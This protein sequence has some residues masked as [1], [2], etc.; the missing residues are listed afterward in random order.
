MATVAEKKQ[1]NLPHF[2][3]PHDDDQRI[4]MGCPEEGENLRW[5][6]REVTGGDTPAAWDDDD[7]LCGYNF[8]WALAD[9]MA[10]AVCEA[11]GAADCRSVHGERYFMELQHRRTKES[12]KPCFT[13][14]KC[15]N[16]L[17]RKAQI[18]RG[19]GEYRG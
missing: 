3:D 17:T 8:E 5:R 9:M 12:G 15:G 2:P 14:T 13:M 7:F 4:R 18:A 1:G 16:I 19:A 11:E 6:Y 10:C